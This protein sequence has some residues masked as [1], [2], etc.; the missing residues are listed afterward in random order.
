MKTITFAFPSSPT[1]RASL[2]MGMSLRDYFAAKALRALIESGRS[3][4][5]EWNSAREG[6]ID[7]TCQVA[8][9]LADRMMEE[10]EKAIER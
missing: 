8:Y 9:R 2:S 7:E 3:G 10:R 6:K 4:A 1:E 5:E